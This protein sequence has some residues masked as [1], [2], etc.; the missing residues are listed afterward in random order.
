VEDSIREAAR[1]WAGLRDAK[2]KSKTA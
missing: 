2:R 1:F